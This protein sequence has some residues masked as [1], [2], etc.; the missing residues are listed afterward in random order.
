MLRPVAPAMR[1][2][3]LGRGGVDLAISAGFH[4]PSGKGGRNA[5]STL[6]SKGFSLALQLNFEK[7]LQFINIHSCKWQQIDIAE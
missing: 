7:I 2:A 1:A 4:K 5:R 6:T 3:G